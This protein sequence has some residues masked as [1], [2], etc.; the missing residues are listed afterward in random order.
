MQAKEKRP[1]FFV[2]SVQFNS[3]KKTAGWVFNHKEKS[4]ANKY[5]D[6][7]LS[8]KSGPSSCLVAAIRFDLNKSFEKKVEEK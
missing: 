8:S 5:D 4:I 1:Q 7:T 3:H 2:N 6:A